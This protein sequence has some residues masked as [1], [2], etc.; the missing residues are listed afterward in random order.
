MSPGG[1][2]LI[3]GQPSGSQP[4][5][6]QNYWNYAPR[7]ASPGYGET[8]ASAMRH[9]ILAPPKLG[10]HRNLA[11]KCR[12]GGCGSAS[13]VT[14]ASGA[15]Q[16]VLAEAAGRL[17]AAIEAGDDLAVNIDDLAGGI[18]AQAGAGVVDY[19]GCPGRIEGWFLD[20]M[21]RGRL[22]EIRIDPAFDKGIVPRHG[23]FEIGRRHRHALVLH[24]D[25]LGEIGEPVGAEEEA[26]SDFDVRR[27]L[28]QGLARH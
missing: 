12:D 4:S 14:L 9:E 10:R 19:R 26:G 25:L 7:R 24:D 23:L 8:E 22:V 6:E 3:F 1:L 5:K 15:G 11:S 18:D 27:L 2:K 20:P 16:P 17:A 28:L 13:D 21:P